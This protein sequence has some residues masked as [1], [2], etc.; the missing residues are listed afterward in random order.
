MTIYAEGVK[1]KNADWVDN[2]LES[3]SVEFECID[4]IL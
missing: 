3:V 1:P 2:L 4:N